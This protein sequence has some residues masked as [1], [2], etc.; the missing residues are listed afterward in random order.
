MSSS[1]QSF[2]NG[3]IQ[4]IR[5]IRVPVIVGPLM[6]LLILV[7]GLSIINP[8]FLSGTNI[9]NL[10]KQ[11]AL[12][13]ILAIG[14]MYIIKMGSIDL[15]VD[16]SMV[17]TS[18]IIGM[19]AA[20]LGMVAAVLAVL[21][22]TLMGFVNGITHTKLRIPAFMSTLG[23]M[24][25][26]LGLGTWLSGGQNLPIRDPIILSWTRESI[27]PLPN[28]TLIGIVMI[29]LGLLIENY[30]RLGRYITAIG[31]AEDRA[32]LVGIPITRYKILAFTVAGF[33][34]GVGGVLN[35]SRNGAGLA[36]AGVGQTFAAITAVAVGGTALTGGTGGVLQTLIG[37]IIVT[38]INNGMVLAG[39]NNLVQM[40]V[41]GVIITIAVILTLD[42][43]KLPF[44]K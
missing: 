2:L 8:L 17:L 20:P 41:Q 38:V 25:I 23:M 18:V 39:V 32:K 36:S 1:T 35:A 42:R 28:L 14:E 30:T 9:A 16:G 22:G 34:I 10:S 40:A 21:A 12:L 27:G 3:K 11:S 5:K 43:S 31:G 29:L 7:T 19:L 24:Y 44:V 33:F 6:V 26:G 15:S 4:T 13:V 37:A